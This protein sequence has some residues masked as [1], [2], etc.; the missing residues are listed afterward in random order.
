[1]RGSDILS[2]G[3]PMRK[4]NIKSSATHHTKEFCEKNAWKSPDFSRGKF[5]EIAIFFKRIGF[6]RTQQIAEFFIEK[7]TLLSEL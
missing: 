3:K 4:I 2:L 6:S 1:L 5:S 7:F